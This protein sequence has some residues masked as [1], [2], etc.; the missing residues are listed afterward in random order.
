MHEG[1]IDFAT[2]KKFFVR[3]I[4]A[5]S[6]SGRLDNTPLRFELERE[7]A[8]LRR[9][10]YGLLRG[11]GPDGPHPTLDVLCRLPGTTRIRIQKGA[12]AAGRTLRD[13]DVRRRTG[14]LILALER[15][16]EVLTN[17]APDLVLEPGDDVLAFADGEALQRLRAEL[18]M[19]PGTGQ[20]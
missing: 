13:L 4:A 18:E 7:Q 20:R 14:A 2:L 15:E 10:G 1:E 11:E 8:A 16:G 3:Q 5:Y 19:A 12:T 17:P 9:E 6:R